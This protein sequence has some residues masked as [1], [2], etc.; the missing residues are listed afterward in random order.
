MRGHGRD[1]KQI[2]NGPPDGCNMTMMSYDESLDNDYYY[3]AAAAVAA[4]DDFDDV[5]AAA[6]VVQPDLFSCVYTF[7]LPP[8]ILCHHQGHRATGSDYAAVEA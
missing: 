5:A 8:S 3:C 2:F 7:Y 4:D 1:S 6:V